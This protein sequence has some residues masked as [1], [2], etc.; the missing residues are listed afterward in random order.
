MK[1]RIL[2][3]LT[4]ILHIKTSSEAIST[5]VAVGT[6]IS[7]LPIPGFSILIGTLIILMFKRVSKIS[8]FLA[9]AFWNPFTLIPVYVASYRLGDLMFQARRV[10]EYDIAVLNRTYYFTE[11]FL[12]GNLVMAVV[13][14]GVAQ[15]AIYY[16]WQYRKSRRARG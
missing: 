11:R 4:D 16:V 5:G 7:I 12:V 14:A 3:H 15:L 13:L 9:M 8:I 1:T 10:V 2:N 6:F